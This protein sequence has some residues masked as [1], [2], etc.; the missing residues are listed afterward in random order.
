MKKP[1]KA[2]TRTKNGPRIP[3]QRMVMI[4]VFSAISIVLVAL[5]H[6]PLFPAAPFLEYDMAD[7][8]IIIVTFLYGPLAGLLTTVI[9]SV[10]Q[11]LTV[12]VGS[13]FIGIL[14]HIFATGCYVLVAGNLYKRHRSLGGE[15]ASLGCGT[16]AMVAVM[17]LWN[18]LLTPLFMKAPFEQVMQL[19]LPAIIPFNLIKA[20]GNSLIAYFVFKAI[21]QVMKRRRA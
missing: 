12:S 14:M 10:L 1:E 15:I 13:G 2:L 8:P 4:A 21:E 19:M 20:G 17:T 16:A 7:V 18:M 11:G 3:V 9:V 5:L 6:V